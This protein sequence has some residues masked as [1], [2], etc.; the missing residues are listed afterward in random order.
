MTFTVTYRDKNGGLV[1][2]P[3]EVES[4]ATLFKALS[5]RGISAVRVVDG[6]S[7]TRHRKVDVSARK[8]A[9]VVAVSVGILAAAMLFIVFRGKASCD[10]N[11]A[12]K[13]RKTLSIV[14]VPTRVKLPVLPAET[15]NSDMI[16]LPNGIITNKPK[17][18][19]EAIKMV[20]LKPGFHSYK[21]VDEVFSK[22]NLFQVGSYKTLNM[23][24]STE[25]QLSLVA[26]RSRTLTLPPLPPLPPHMEK[27]FEIAMNNYLVEMEGDTEADIAQKKKIEMFKD[28]MHHYVFEKGMTPS[29]AMQEIQN[30]HNRSANLYQLY[31]GEYIKLVRQNS[32]DADA[33]YD[34]AVGKLKEKGA[35]LF[36]RDANHIEE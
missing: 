5:G 13:P 11:S 18:I 30:D 15:N 14:E 4:R 24:S 20:R 3:F 31:R 29:Q 21:D 35:P 33:F 8:V 7:G 27:D 36:D 16:V 32:P 22:T 19:A 28:M 6:V 17:T 26:T 10:A 25:A 2:E 12:P 1:S 9:I 23:K 34:A